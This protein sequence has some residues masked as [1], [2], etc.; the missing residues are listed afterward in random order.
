MQECPL[1]F[2]PMVRI[3]C[4]TF[5]KAESQFS[6]A[7]NRRLILGL[8]STEASFLGGASIS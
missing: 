7:L 6:Y 8:K 5:E 3:R 4:G 2:Q 1:G